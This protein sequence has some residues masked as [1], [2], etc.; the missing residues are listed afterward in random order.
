MTV[1]WPRPSDRHRLLS[2][3][4]DASIRYHHIHGG[5]VAVA[6]DEQGSPTAAAD[7]DPPNRSSQSLLSTVRAS[8]H[9]IAALRSALPR[10]IG[11]RRTLDRRQPEEPHWYLAHIGTVGD[12]RGRGYASGIMRQQLE[13][14]DQQY[15]PAYLVSTRPETVPFY[16]RF[17]FD[18][19]TEFPLVSDGPVMTGM[20][21]PPRSRKSIQC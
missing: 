4:F 5:G 18:V 17:G 14:I 20:W 8:P 11:V 2:R 7:W 16:R 21:R 12:A 1:L 10:A 3:Y 13:T 19:T 15:L 9:L 6:F